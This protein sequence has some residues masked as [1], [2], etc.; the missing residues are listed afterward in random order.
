MNRIVLSGGGFRNPREGFADCRHYCCKP[1]HH[2][3]A[4]GQPGRVSRPLQGGIP[5]GRGAADSDKT[6]KLGLFQRQGGRHLWSKD[7][8]CGDLFSKKERTDRRRASRALP[9]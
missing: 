4:A 6:E 3:P 9:L 5:W 1:P 7:P 8:G 2:C